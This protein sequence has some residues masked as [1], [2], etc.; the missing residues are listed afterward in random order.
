[1]LSWLVG[2]GVRGCGIEGVRFRFAHPLIRLA[3]TGPLPLRE[4]AKSLDRS[5]SAISQTVAAVR[6][7]GL[8]TSEPG[9]DARTRR[10][11][12]AQQSGAS[13]SVDLARW[14]FPAAYAIRAMAMAVSMLS[15]IRLPA[16]PSAC[17]SPPS[18]SGESPPVGSP[19]R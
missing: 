8:V 9:P 6:K 17:S 10:I 5:H 7:E 11:D 12:L 15:V 2:W 16:G 4:L 14:D 1:M 19:A 18:R 13:W 3:H